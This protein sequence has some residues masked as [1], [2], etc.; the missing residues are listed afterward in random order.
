MTLW[1]VRVYEPGGDFSTVFA[2]PDM[3]DAQESVERING[4][5]SALKAK[6]GDVTLLNVAAEIT[7]W[8]GTAEE[9]AFG[10]AEQRREQ[11]ELLEET[12]HT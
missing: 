7:K 2:S 10:L 3:D 8:P 11:E 12:E 6:H 4:F 5:V 9:H 1:A